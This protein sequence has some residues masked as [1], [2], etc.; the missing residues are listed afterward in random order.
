M[1]PLSTV[2]E[3]RRLFFAEHWKIGTIAVQLNLHHQTVASALQTERFLSRG[4]STKSALDPFAPF[5][6]KTLEEYPRLTATRIH[7]MLSDRGYTGSPVQVRR[8]V[9]RIRPT[10][11]PEAFFRLSKFPGEEAQ[12]DWG[13]FGKLRVGNT[14]RDL[15]AFVMVL[16]WSRA[17]HV[18][19][20]L[21]QRVESFLRGHVLAMD[22]FGGAPRTLLLDN[23]KAGVLQ[24][25][26]QAIE[27]HPAFLQMCA[28]YHILPKP[29]GIARGNEKGGVERGIR[30]LRDNFV[31]ARTFHSVEDANSQFLLWRD[32][33]AHTRPWPGDPTTTVRD[34]FDKERERLLPLPAGPFSCDVLKAVRSGKQPYVRFDANDYSIPWTLVRKPMTLAATHDTIR[35]LDGA[36]EIARHPRSWERGRLVEDDAHFKGLAERKAQ[37][38][39]SR[40]RSHLSSVVPEVGPLL[41]YAVLHG[42]HVGSVTSQ[43]LRLLDLY[44]AEALRTAVVEA[45]KRGTHAPS[46]VAHILEVQRRS[47]RMAPPIPVI[48]PNRAHVR[49]LTVI[50][51]N[52]ES[53]DAL[54][55]NNDDEQD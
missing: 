53:Y 18:V 15:S 5:I 16:A 22:A 6:Q 21:D 4:R 23:L 28:H 40:G 41:E 52:L 48:L 51:H 14:M 19:F 37:A 3:I 1:I 17:I 44:G 30:Y 9:K 25:H 34:A 38:R 35:I 12:V 39:T 46:S 8:L 49:T 45:T 32:R 27:F 2:V 7:Q 29:V 11:Q 43:L 54:A 36:L 24:R 50:P 10:R 31:P 13:S 42:A 33:W 47:A 26:G 20:T 55:R